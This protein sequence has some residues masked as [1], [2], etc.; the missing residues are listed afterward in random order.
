MKYR[1]NTLKTLLFTFPV[2]LLT[3]SV[4][5]Q[6]GEN[7]VNNPSFED[8]Q[9][10]KIRRIGDM[11]RADGWVS[12]TGERADLFSADANLPEVMTPENVYGKEEPKTGIN[13]AGVKTYSYREKE[14]RTYI[15]SQLVSPLKKGMRYKVQFYA[16]LAELSK[17]S[18]NRLAAHFSKKPIGSDDKIPAIILA[19][20]EIH[21]EHPK[22]EVFGGMYGWDLVCGEYVATGKEKYI[23]I[24]NFSLDKDIKSERVRKPRDIRGSQV[25]A[26]Y[27]YIDDVSVQLLGPDEQCDCNYA[28]EAQIRTSTVYQ[29]APEITKDMTAKDKIEQFNIFY[30]Y[31]RY[32]VK[33]DGLKTLDRI[34]EIMKENPDMKI[35]ISG[36]SDADE[37]VAASDKIVSLRRA[38]YI[39][40]LL[41]KRGVDEDRLIIEDVKNGKDS[42]FINEEDDE[43][44]INAKNRRVTFKAL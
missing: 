11:K 28:D 8:A 30:L 38:E 2:L 10:R 32:D 13:Y 19:E 16:S 25:I 43:K 34:A 31:G 7:L 24:G 44:L 3:F 18:A 29:R 33:V 37:A 36:H 35:K 41:G 5:A 39:V 20:D 1:T 21:V 12:A 14:N 40:T 27:Y 4:Q 42:K 22:K 23:T 9:N 17:Y 15:T 26:A 6:E